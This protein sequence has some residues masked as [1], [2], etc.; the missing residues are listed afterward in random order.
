MDANTRDE[1]GGSAGECIRNAGLAFALAT[2]AIVMRFGIFCLL[3]FV[4][5]PFSAPL[6]HVRPVGA[7]VLHDALV[8][9]KTQSAE[10]G[11]R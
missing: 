6:A 3:L 5:L 1:N 9:S 4:F 8:E 10:N 7:L 2:A 11:C